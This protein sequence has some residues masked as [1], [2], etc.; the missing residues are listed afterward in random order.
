M[1]SPFYTGYYWALLLVIVGFPPTEYTYI[2]G[3]NYQ[4][5]LN[6]ERV[7]FSCWWRYSNR[8]YWQK[9]QHQ[10][11]CDSNYQNLFPHYR[12]F[13]LKIR[14]CESMLIGPNYSIRVQILLL[15]FLCSRIDN[16]SCNQKSFSIQLLIHSKLYFFF[17]K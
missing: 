14:E 12:L 17:V 13:F 15:T 7:S 8:R 1:R 9:S 3:T 4:L 11:C 5:A 16:S 10:K 2:V 6:V